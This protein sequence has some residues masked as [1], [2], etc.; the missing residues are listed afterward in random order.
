MRG[1]GL[2]RSPNYERDSGASG[3]EGLGGGGGVL[4]LERAVEKGVDSYSRGIWTRLDS[5]GFIGLG[6]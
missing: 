2:Q 6:S 4:H 1:L 3:L 5:F